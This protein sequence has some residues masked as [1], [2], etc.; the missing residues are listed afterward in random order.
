MVAKY[1]RQSENDLNGPKSRLIISVKQNVTLTR[2][3]RQ[4]KKS[5]WPCYTQCRFTPNSLKSYQILKI[6]GWLLE[7]M[8]FD[9]IWPPKMA[10]QDGRQS[11]N[12]LDHVTRGIELP[13]M[14]QSPTR[15]L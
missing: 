4:L 6:C 12:D 3:G 14:A 8:T 5:P 2:D 7:N 1:G 13:L 10:G 11:K 15:I 9:P